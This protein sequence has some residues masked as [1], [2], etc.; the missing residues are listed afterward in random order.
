MT[1]RAML[2]GWGDDSRLD[3]RPVQPAPAYRRG[4]G[5]G[6]EGG[7]GASRPAAGLVQV[8]DAKG[9]TEVLLL[10]PLTWIHVTTLGLVPHAHGVHAPLTTCSF[11]VHS[12]AHASSTWGSRQSC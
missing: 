11:S 12:W 10:A 1:K 9:P 6:A 4:S 2:R 8:H 3:L 5:G 7:R